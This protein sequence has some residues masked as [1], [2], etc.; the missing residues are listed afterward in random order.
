M[1]DA[2]WSIRLQEV[3][4]PEED[5]SDARANLRELRKRWATVTGVP[6]PHPVG[7]LGQPRLVPRARMEV[8]LD[9]ECRE[10]ARLLCEL[11]GA[12]VHA[13]VHPDTREEVDPDAARLSLEELLAPTADEAKGDPKL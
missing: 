2:L 6:E 10:A 12:V 7:A 8:D 3:D 11:H 13:L 9:E 1:E 5:V 4:L